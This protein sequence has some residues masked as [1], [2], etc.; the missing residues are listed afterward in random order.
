M[1]LTVI[2]HMQVVGSSYMPSEKKVQYSDV[3]PTKVHMC[4]QCFSFQPGRTS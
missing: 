3:K 1:R 2:V 4:A